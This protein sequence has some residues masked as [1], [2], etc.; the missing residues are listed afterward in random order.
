VQRRGFELFR[1]KTNSIIESVALQTLDGVW[2][3]SRFG[4]ELSKT[5]ASIDLSGLKVLDLGCGCGIQGIVAAKSGASEVFASDISGKSVEATIAN[6]KAN[7]VLIHARAGDGLQ[8]WSG[9]SFDVVICNG[10]TYS[11]P[12]AGDTVQKEFHERLIQLPRIT[13]DLIRSSRQMLSRNGFVILLVCGPYAGVMAQEEL[14]R[15][16]F[17]IDLTRPLTLTGAPAD[18]GLQFAKTTITDSNL[19]ADL[20]DGVVEV[21]AEIVVASLR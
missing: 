1:L 15:A 6:A 19:G 12:S 5:I 11:V 4:I 18:L 21:T 8:T 13:L 2:A 7:G 17:R 20:G 14:K 3:P 9:M 16:N 10:P